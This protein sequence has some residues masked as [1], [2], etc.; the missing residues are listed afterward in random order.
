MRIARGGWL[1]LVAGGMDPTDF[2]VNWSH[3]NKIPPLTKYGATVQL[4]L[5][6][7]LFTQNSH[8][9]SSWCWLF[10]FVRFQICAQPSGYNSFLASKSN[11]GK[12]F[13]KKCLV[14]GGKEE[15]RKKRRKYLKKEDIW[16]VEEMKNREGRIEKL[17]NDHRSG[18][19]LVIDNNKKIKI[20]NLEET[21][22]DKC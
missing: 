17:T 20:E 8:C 21:V 12:Y 13:E 6:G 22:G 3:P 15:R 2:N 16:S 1:G 10:I 5:L 18:F 7:P 9:F 14:S 4:W 19:C 11:W